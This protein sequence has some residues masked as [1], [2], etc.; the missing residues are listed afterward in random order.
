MKI[1]DGFNHYI[2]EHIMNILLQKPIM[3]TGVI[4]QFSINKLFQLDGRCQQLLLLE[5][6]FTVILYLMKIGA[7]KRVIQKSKFSRF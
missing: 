4:L 3:I 5:D 2:L 6:I 7:Y 1:K